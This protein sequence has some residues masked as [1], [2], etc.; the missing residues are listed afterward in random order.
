MVIR[1]LTLFLTC[2]FLST[3][4]DREVLD[5]TTFTLQPFISYCVE[6]LERKGGGTVCP[7]LGS[8]IGYVS[9][10]SIEMCMAVFVSLSSCT[11]HCI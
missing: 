5:F 10:P 4:V 6:L 11:L 7:Y 2:V 3:R 9:R 1:T 8:D